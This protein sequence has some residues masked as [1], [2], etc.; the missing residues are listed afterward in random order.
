MSMSPGVFLSSATGGQTTQQVNG[1]VYPFTPIDTNKS[2]PSTPPSSSKSNISIDLYQK[3]LEADKDDNT[4]IPLPVVTPLSPFR[5]AFGITSPRRNIKSKTQIDSPSPYFKKT[6][7]ERIAK[8]E[9]THP[10]II[11]KRNSTR[12][13]VIKESPPF[14]TIQSQKHQRLI[15]PTKLGAPIPKVLG[16]MPPSEPLGLGDGRVFNVSNGRSRLYGPRVMP[17]PVSARKIPSNT[18][19]KHT[20]SKPAM[21]EASPVKDTKPTDLVYG[22]P[23][24]EERMSTPS[25]NC[26]ATQINRL[27]SLS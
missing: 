2:L 11:A 26:L 25:L 23:L 13:V 12:R 27:T 20:T 3:L 10:L 14:P 9:N 7:K 8:W 4:F 24:P 21:K 16:T 17:S 15:T 19:P 5:V 1:T 18:L 22:Y 6:V